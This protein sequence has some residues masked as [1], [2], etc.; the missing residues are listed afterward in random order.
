MQTKLIYVSLFLLIG[1]LLHGQNKK[2]ELVSLT[3]SPNI[4]IGQSYTYPFYQKVEANFRLFDKATFKYSQGLFSATYGENKDMMSFVSQT[5]LIQSLGLNITPI[6][7]KRFRLQMG[8]GLAHIYYKDFRTQSTNTV[9]YGSDDDYTKIRFHHLVNDQQSKIGVDFYTDLEFMV[10]GHLAFSLAA[11]ATN[12]KSGLQKD[13]GYY[14]F[15]A[16]LVYYIDN[17][18]LYKQ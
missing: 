5:G 4:I 9:T 7:Y 15:G 6:N 16:N 14:H 2:A 1:I 13:Y 3:Y 12:F 18:L 10:S 17:Q 11:N 8:L